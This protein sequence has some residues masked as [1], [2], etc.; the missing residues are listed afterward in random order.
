MEINEQYRILI[1][2]DEA[3]I[4]EFLTFNLERAGYLVHAAENG[5]KAI[6][7]VRQEK[8]H[9]II[10]DVMMPEMDGIE[11]VR[12]IRHLPDCKQI[13]VVF[14]S[15]R[16]EDYTQI[17]S[18]DAGGDVFIT[19]PIKPRLLISK[20]NALFKR[21]K[22]EDNGKMLIAGDLKI[23]RE[24]HKVFIV[25]AA[26]DLPRKEF[27][28][29]CLFAEKP[30]KVFLRNEIM[31]KVWGNDVIVGDRTLDV[32]IR[33][34]RQKLGDELIQTVKGVGYKLLSE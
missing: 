16:G 15:A 7:M 20:I 33:R 6:E 31:R 2:D 9:L 29:L 24:K 19:K 8:P 13:L 26:V 1:V 25:D 30:G 18:L 3:D 11:T 5:T 23:D 4:I 32:H 17:A 22:S 27:D 21:L 28:L 14:L 34:I 10:M 12:R